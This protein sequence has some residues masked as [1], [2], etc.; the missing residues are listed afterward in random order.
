MPSSSNSSGGG[1][2]IAGCLFLI[3]VVLT[4]AE[5]GAVAKWSWWWVCSPLW[6]P[7]CV[8][9]AVLLVVGVFIAVRSGL[10]VIGEWFSRRNRL[11]HFSDD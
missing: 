4:L 7:V 6:I 1:I 8:V 2:G 11:K 3:F 9:L 10:G 5:V